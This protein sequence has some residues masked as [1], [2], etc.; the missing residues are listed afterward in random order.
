MTDT[1]LK[2]YDARW[3]T[4]DFSRM[5]IEKLFRSTCIYAEKLNIDTIVISRDARLGCP[6]VVEI[7]VK[8]AR[9]SGF[10]V[11]LCQDP[12]S[13]PQSYYNTLRITENHPNTM[14]WTITAS[15]NPSSYIGVKFVISPVRA[16]GMESGPFDGLT[17]IEKIYFNG[18]R[19]DIHFKN[20]HYGKLFLINY[21]TDYVAD[22]LEW[23]SVSRNELQG[24]NVILN[25]MNGSAGTEVYNTLMA[26]GV[27]ITALNLIVNGAFPAG[28]PNP[29][30]KG[31]MNRAIELA[32][33]QKNA[34]V[35]GLDGD[36]DRIIFGDKKG[37]FTAGTSMI[38]LLSR[39]KVIDPS[40]LGSA[41]CDPKV[42][43]SSLDNWSR[44]GYTPILFRNGHSQIKDYMRSRDISVAAEESGHFYHRIQK[45]NLTV[46]CENSLI[47]ILL[48]LKSIKENP[49]LLSDMR[50]IEDSVFTSREINYQ[51]TD[52]MVRNKA[53]N[54]AVSLLQKD[55]AVISSKTEEGIDLQGIAFLKGVNPRTKRLEG[56]D[57]YSG[58][59]RIST[60]EKSV[61]RFYFSSGSESMCNKLT[62]E[63]RKVC[64]N[65]LSGIRI[66]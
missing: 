61:A 39:L 6:E 47:T 7:A 56:K 57:W 40:T 55:N 36:G 14:G 60:N 48:F 64:E 34:I 22:S 30:S 38:P 50:A 28:A 27:N 37:L 17:D 53:L 54:T 46:Y 51:F 18:N 32:G 49:V 58:F 4:G 52:D 3:E 29:T 21:S 62:N 44:L 26:A 2:V 10:T 31:K 19:G 65:D 43:P 8:T 42:D 24:M 33:N 9:S 59:H 63:I 16:I 25:P 20:S 45:N 1:P 23:A 66:E 35:I 12:I 13:T 5:E 11:Y 15:H 41:L